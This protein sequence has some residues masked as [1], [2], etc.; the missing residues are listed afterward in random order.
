MDRFYDDPFGLDPLGRLPSRGRRRAA[1]PL[2][3]DP[4]SPVDSRARRTD[5]DGGDSED[6]EG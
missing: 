6:A 3:L 2:V 5:A 1:D 4:L